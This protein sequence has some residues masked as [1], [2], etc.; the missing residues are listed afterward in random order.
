MDRSD[1][2]HD[3]LLR[4]RVP[5]GAGSP[6]SLSRPALDIEHLI[7]PTVRERMF[8]MERS[9]ESR[10][11]R[12]RT[13]V[14]SG[15]GSPRSLRSPELDIERLMPPPLW[16]VCLREPVV[17]GCMLELFKLVLSRCLIK[18]E[19]E[20]GGATFDVNVMA[21]NT[22]ADASVMRRARRKRSV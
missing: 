1:E 20:E 13:R 7:A 22:S 15:A 6:R 21:P 17:L 9:D 3:T 11:P 19:G 16:C 10:D 12:L 18:G 2:S 14:P 5:S 4:T 8:V